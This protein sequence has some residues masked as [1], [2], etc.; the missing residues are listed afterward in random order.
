MRE[1]GLQ[2]LSVSSRRGDIMAVAISLQSG[3]IWTT[4]RRAIW[5]PIGRSESGR[6]NHSGHASRRADVIAAL[7]HDAGGSFGVTTVH[8][9][10]TPHRG[11]LVV[12]N[13]CG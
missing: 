7:T 12:A 4:S 5:V 9:A 1:L 11:K 6:G 10:A 13:A 2:N 3:G 8:V